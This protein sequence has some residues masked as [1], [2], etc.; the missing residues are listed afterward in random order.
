MFDGI[1]ARYDLVNR[2]L[3]LG[4]DQRWRRALVRA[5]GL[6]PGAR[7]VDLATG[8]G[9]VAIAIARAID[10]VR[11][12]GID[13]SAA[14]LREAARKIGAAGLGERIELA[15]GDASALPVPTAAAD[16]VAIA[17][18]IRNV[19]DR[20]AALAEVRRVLVPGGRLAVL[21]LTDPGGA[22]A[23][24]HVHRLV[25]R[26]GALFS[27]REPYG[28]L[29]R[30]IAAFPPAAAF[31]AELADAGLEPEPPRPFGLGATHLFLA[32]RS[33]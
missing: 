28:Y 26:I 33:S 17:F 11:V 27:S 15:R 12:L 23:R 10:G 13:P 8:T 3:S 7:V 19:P 2:V 1:A 29:A 31:A 20:R 14:M 16:A 22:L 6:A 5:L 25:P 32:R 9:D 4:L 30:S 24:L 18:G 21:E